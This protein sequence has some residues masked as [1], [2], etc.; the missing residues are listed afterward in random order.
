MLTVTVTFSFTDGYNNTCYYH[1]PANSF[2]RV[3]ISAI[4]Q[5]RSRQREFT[6]FQ[7][8]LSCP[9]MNIDFASHVTSIRP[10]S[11]YT[12]FSRLLSP[13]ISYLRHVELLAVRGN[14]LIAPTFL[15]ENAF[16]HPPSTSLSRFIIRVSTEILWILL[17]SPCVFSQPCWSCQAAELFGDT[18]QGEIHGTR[19]DG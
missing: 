18:N 7:C 15:P 11:G 10:L 1:N 16:V 2:S 13:F 12:L 14:D 5:S 4:S 6:S 9:K 19:N 8:L 17:L 3:A